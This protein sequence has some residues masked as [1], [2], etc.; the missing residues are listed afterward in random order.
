MKEKLNLGKEEKPSYHIIYPHFIWLFVQGVFLFLF[1]M[2]WCYG[3][4]KPCLCVDTTTPLHEGDTGCMNQ[5]I[6]DP[7]IVEDRNPTLHYGNGFNRYL[8]WS[9]NLQFSFPE[10]DIIQM[11]NHLSTAFLC[12]L[13]HPDLA[14]V[15]STTFNKWLT[16]PVSSIFGAQNAP[17]DFGILAEGRSHVAHYLPLEALHSKPDLIELM[18]PSKSPSLEFARWAKAFLDELNPGIAGMDT[19]SPEAQN[20]MFV[21]NIATAHVWEHFLTAATPL[22]LL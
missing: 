6:S 2:V 8:A 3:D 14:V 10:E 15:Y 12:V 13:Y 19:D 17:G 1:C 20:L 5:Y 7:I 18:L 9:W 22:T 4:L 11:A 16:V 21:D